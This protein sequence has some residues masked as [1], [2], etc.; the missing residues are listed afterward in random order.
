M[1]VSTVRVFVIIDVIRLSPTSQES[2]SKRWCHAGGDWL[3][4]RRCSGCHKEGRG[5]IGNR[6][7]W[8]MGMAPRSLVRD[9][10]GRV[11]RQRLR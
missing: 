3:D 11:A 9:L 7:R 8:N 2:Y 6:D 5:A 10:R 4:G 1:V